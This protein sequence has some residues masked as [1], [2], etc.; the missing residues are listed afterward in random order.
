MLFLETLFVIA[1]TIGI[2]D[3]LILI[4]V[5]GGFGI[6][7][8]VISQSV[9]GLIGLWLL[10]KLDFSLFFFLDV[11]LKNRQRII[12]E[13]WEEA[14]LLAAACLLIMPGLL[15]DLIGLLGLVPPLRRWWLNH[16]GEDLL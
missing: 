10:R 12:R 3:L 7:F 4:R 9:T 8:I 11:E 1:L 14:W 15:S 16:F 6:V 5:A 2:T 13:L